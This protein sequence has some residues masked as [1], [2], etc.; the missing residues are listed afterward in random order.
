MQNNKKK[1]FYGFFYKFYEIFDFDHNFDT[2]GHIYWSHVHQFLEKTSVPPPLI[3]KNSKGHHNMSSHVLIFFKIKVTLCLFSGETDSL[4]RKKKK[5]C[6]H[7]FL[8]IS[9]RR[10][11]WTFIKLKPLHQFTSVYTR[12]DFKLCQILL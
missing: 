7:H 12:I 4:V 11:V 3:R 9:Q 2:R 5:K 1:F 6:F 8:I 10:G